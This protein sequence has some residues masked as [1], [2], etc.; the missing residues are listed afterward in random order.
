MDINI[1]VCSD[2]KFIMPTGVMIY[3]VCKNNE[4][5]EVNFH[6]IIDESVTTEN[7]KKLE[8]IVVKFNNH[9][10]FYCIDS[11]VTQRFPSI[12]Y[13]S[14]ATY[15]RLYMAEILPASL[16]RVLYLDGDIIVRGDLSSLWEIDLAGYAVAATPSQGEAGFWNYKDLGYSQDLGYFNAGVLLV[17]LEYWRTNDVKSE[18]EDFINK[19]PERIRLVDQ[20]V[21][22]YVFRGKKKHLPIKYNFQHGFLFAKPNYDWEKYKDEVIEA[23]HN[24]IIVHYA[25]GKPWAHNM[26][27][28]PHPFRSLWFKYSNETCWKNEKLWERRTLTYKV[29]K[30]VGNFLRKIKLL[31][32][33]KPNG[34]EYIDIEPI[35]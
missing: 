13:I 29:K 1:V 25:G 24:P 35:D 30:S 31:P 14:Q 8:E 2:N 19:Y 22:N 10:F 17:N 34:T 20:D 15:Y 18:F 16:S 27:R 9:L 26:E 33:L 7:K 4:N 6:V 23:R 32:E 11:S 28:Y 5:R 12:T 3:S 21:L